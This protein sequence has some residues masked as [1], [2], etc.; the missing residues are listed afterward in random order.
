MDAPVR[1]RR[2]GILL[3]CRLTNSYPPV[4]QVDREVEF[5]GSQASLPVTDPQGRHQE[6]RTQVGGMLPLPET[7]AARQAAGDPRPSI[8]ELYPTAGTYAAAV[9]TAAGRLVA[10]RLQGQLR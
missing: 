5:W 9:Q 7:R 2:D 1:G 3:R 10:E 4:M 8:E 6:I